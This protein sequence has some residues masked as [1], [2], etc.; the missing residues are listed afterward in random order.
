MAVTDLSNAKKALLV[1]LIAVFILSLVGFA[2]SAFNVFYSNSKHFELRQRVLSDTGNESGLQGAE[3]SDTAW[4]EFE[5]NWDELKSIN[6]ETVA[7]LRIPNTNVEQPV[8]Q[9]SDNEKYIHECFDKS[10]ADFGQGAIF[11]DHRNSADFEDDNNIMYGHNMLDG[12]MFADIS[13]YINQDFLEQHDVAYIYTP[14]NAYKLEIFCSVEV[15]GQDLINTPNFDGDEGFDAYIDDML[16]RCTFTKSHY[17]LDPKDSE[18]IFSFYTCVDDP[19][20]DRRIVAFASV[21]EVV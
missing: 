5:V 15:D 13:E 2:V 1:A 16:S 7:W 3:M 9:T 18:K 12:S 20:I 4:R 11:L 21:V 14:K 10:D 8:V 17:E 6:P 19:S